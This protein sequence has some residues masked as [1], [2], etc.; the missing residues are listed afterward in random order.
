MLSQ[1]AHRHH[2]SRGCVAEVK[3]AEL[4][5]MVLGGELVFKMCRLHLVLLLPEVQTLSNLQHDRCV[6]V[7]LCAIMSVA[8]PALMVVIFLQVCGSLVEP[9]AGYFDKVFVMSEDVAVRQ[10][11]LALL[12]DT[13]GV[14]SGI[15]D[16]A[17]LPGF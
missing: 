17:E 3:P 15:I 5:T 4:K 7:H 2:L 8:N 9:I 14:T 16:F 1:A 13:A 10:S 6:I 11:R 12:R